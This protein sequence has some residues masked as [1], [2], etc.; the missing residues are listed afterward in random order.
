MMMMCVCVL[1]SCA[2]VLV[3]FLIFKSSF[4]RLVVN[5][6]EAFLHYSSDHIARAP[7]ISFGS[8]SIN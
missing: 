8:A 1:L 7:H 2:I 3:Q 6:F 4:T 5:P